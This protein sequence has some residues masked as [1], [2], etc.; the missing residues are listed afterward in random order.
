[1]RGWEANIFVN[2]KEVYKEKGPGKQV[3]VNIENCFLSECE[4]LPPPP[5]KNSTGKTQCKKLSNRLNPLLLMFF[6]VE[7]CNLSWKMHHLATKTNIDACTDNAGK[8]GLQS[9]YYI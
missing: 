6:I 7:N 9:E 8:R 5:A 1:M 2:K 4:D 3:D